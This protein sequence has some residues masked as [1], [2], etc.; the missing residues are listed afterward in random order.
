MMRR[1]GTQQVNLYVMVVIIGCGNVAA[2]AAVAVVVVVM[3][4][5]VVEVVAGNECLETCSCWTFPK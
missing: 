5:L 1:Q 2:V 3:V 4:F